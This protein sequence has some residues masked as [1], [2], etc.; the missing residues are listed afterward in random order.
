M[1]C[2]K[3]LMPVESLTV[4]PRLVVEAALEDV[5]VIAQNLFGS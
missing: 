3:I 2:F 5:D 4:E 1:P